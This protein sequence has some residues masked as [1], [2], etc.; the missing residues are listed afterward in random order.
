MG[1][2]VSDPD[3]PPRKQGGRDFEALATDKY[4]EGPRAWTSPSQG[5]HF[6]DRHKVGMGG[7]CVAKREIKR[8]TYS[9]EGD[10]GRGRGTGFELECLCRE[11][12]EISLVSTQWEREERLVQCVSVEYILE[13]LWLRRDLA[14]KRISPGVIIKILQ[15]SSN[16]SSTV[17]T[18]I[19]RITEQNRKRSIKSI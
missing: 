5:R 18:S 12:K 11:G 2:T 15:E 3:S 13:I 8:F 17:S 6:A 10:A 19:S 4:S 14:V 9:M 16:S 7:E 1:R